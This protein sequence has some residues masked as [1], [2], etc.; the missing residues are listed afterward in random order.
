[1]RASSKSAN[2]V[3]AFKKSF[4]FLAEYFWSGRGSYYYKPFVKFHEVLE[5]KLINIKKYF[6]IIA[7]PRGFGKSKIVSVLYAIWSV[8]VGVDV[9]VKRNGVEVTEVARRSY[10]LLVSM[11]QKKAKQNLRDIKDLISISR[12]TKIFPYEIE[13]WRA[14]TVKIKLKNRKGDIIHTV[15]VEAVGIG[16]QILGFS[17]GAAR[18]DLIIFDDLED[19]ESVL[20]KERVDKLEKWINAEVLPGR[21]K[22]DPWERPAE[23]ILI[24]TPFDADCMLSR[25][26]LGRW[27]KNVAV[28]TFPALVE[29]EQ[30]SLE[31]GI[32]ID[33]SIWE[34]LHP[35]HTRDGIIG[36]H[37]EREDYNL[38]GMIADFRMQYQMDANADK[39]LT[40]DH[41]KFVFISKRDAQK[42]L[43]RIVVVF[44]M[45]Y[46]QNTTSDYV[47]VSV[48]S[49]QPNSIMHIL[50]GFQERWTMNQCWE[51][52]VECEIK[53]G[54]LIQGF[55]AETNQAQLVERIFHENN[56]KGF[57]NII[58]SG[59]KERHTW[60]KQ[61]RIQTLLPF[62]ET[63][64]IKLIEENCYAVIGQM[65]SFSG[66]RVASGH[67]DAID[68]LSYQT[69]FAER[70]IAKPPGEPE[71]RA[72]N[73]VDANEYFKMKD[74]V[75]QINLFEA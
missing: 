16:Q 63:G 75:H 8:F 5:Y 37:E 41:D 28:I 10:V 7:I 15:L 35:T 70:S 4:L 30:Q 26:M 42:K 53:Y 39:K 36:L 73:E 66:S 51:F 18:P 55:Y 44:D 56:V 40:F 9:K 71:P 14:D 43:N 24:G 57:R 12:F 65:R 22:N 13:M 74:K 38:K 23:V 3:R 33:Q 54:E 47:G 17:E 68:A 20:N 50:E 48:A 19:T 2:F 52:C 27:R 46:T 25:A 6:K 72:W 62:H 49:H 32:P 45:A 60:K 29:T 64:R 11:S 34:E 58:I 31:L 59:I 61:N 67:D 1:M 69:L 21:S